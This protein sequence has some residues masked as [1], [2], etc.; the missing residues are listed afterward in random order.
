MAVTIDLDNHN[1][2]HPPNKID[3]GERLARWPLAKVYSRKIHF[4]GPLYRA[5]TI[6]P[7]AI[8]VAFEYV[9]EG[10]MIG[11]AGV[12]KVTELK[13]GTLNGFEVADKAGAWHAAKAVIQGKGVVVRNDAVKEPV[14]LRYACHPQA[15]KDR[16]WNLYNKAGL[17]ASPFCSDW[18]KMPYDPGRNP[19][20]R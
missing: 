19:M 11:I 14:A 4:S 17:P 6:K 7:G 20:P 18:S 16:P 3:V 5:V 9:N 2:I 10:L 1:D 12:G 15:T 8:H 13:D